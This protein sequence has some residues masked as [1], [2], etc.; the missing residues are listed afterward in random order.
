MFGRLF[1]L[2]GLLAF[3]LISCNEVTNS[4]GGFLGG[5]PCDEVDCGNGHC[6]NGKCICDEGYEGRNC[7]KEIVPSR[8]VINTI[9]LT[10]FPLKKGEYD[11]D[12]WS[13]Y[14]DIY[15]KLKK[16]NETVYVLEEF[17]EEAGARYYTLYN[18]SIVLEDPLSQYTIELYD[19]DSTS[20]DELLGKCSFIPYKKGNSFPEELNLTNQ[21]VS[22]HILLTYY[23]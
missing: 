6:D 8:V 19:Y 5:N 1:S 16:N 12:T 23:W 13:S 4:E 10:N 3:M 21:S 14:A 18:G 17:I 9:N 11:W 20:E 2:V 22:F 7:K 15:F